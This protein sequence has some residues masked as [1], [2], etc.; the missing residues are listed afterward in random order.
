[1]ASRPTGG[2]GEQMGME[3]GDLRAERE[4]LHDLGGQAGAMDAA[5][6]VSSRGFLVEE[7]C[8]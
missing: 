5:P 6:R 7:P 4:A 3:A 8:P 1:M 2:D